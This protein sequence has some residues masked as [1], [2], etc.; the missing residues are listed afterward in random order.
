MLTSELRMLRHD[1][2]G[3]EISSDRTN[4]IENGFMLLPSFPQAKHSMYLCSTSQKCPVVYNALIQIKLNFI[5]CVSI[6]KISCMAF[7]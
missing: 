1:S 5:Y 2:L 7:D 6:Q 3:N 4:G